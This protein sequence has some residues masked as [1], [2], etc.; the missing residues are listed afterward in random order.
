MERELKG[1]EIMNLRESK[2]E[3][4]YIGGVG[5]KKRE[6]MSLYFNFKK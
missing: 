5:R 4:G 6:M 3:V 1:K 2:I